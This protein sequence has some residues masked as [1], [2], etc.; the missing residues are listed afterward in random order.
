MIGTTIKIK[1]IHKKA[2]ECITDDIDRGHNILNIG[3]YH[4]KKGR[5]RLFKLISN[6]Y[7]ET[8]KYH[9]VLKRENWEIVII[10]NKTK[11]E[12]STK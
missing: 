4:I 10:D 6:E 9:Y 12:I 1:D 3:E 11:K 2:I 7:P 8:K 5:D